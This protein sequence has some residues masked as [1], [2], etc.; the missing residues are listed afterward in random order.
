MLS[1][2]TEQRIKLLLGYLPFSSYM[3][4]HDLPMELEHKAYWA[5]KQL[6]FAYDSAGDKCKLQLNKLDE[7]HNEEYKNANIYKEKTKG[8][9]DNQIQKRVSTKLENVIV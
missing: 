2:H 1:R 3:G 7:I 8:F 6:N 5:I 9:H 4:K